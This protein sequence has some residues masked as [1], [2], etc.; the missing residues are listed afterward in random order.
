M[1]II[2]KE[3]RQDIE[4]LEYNLYE[5]EVLDDNTVIAKVEETL[6]KTWKYGKKKMERK[7]ERVL[8]YIMWMDCLQTR[9]GHVV[10]HI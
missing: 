1:H 8:S 2:E 9:N 3:I 7:K 5:I 4:S 6:N 10:K